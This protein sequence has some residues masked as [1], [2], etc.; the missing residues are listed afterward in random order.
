MV[1]GM[2]SGDD[3][4]KRNMVKAVKD[5]CGL[6]LAEHEGKW[7]MEIG[8]DFGDASNADGIVD[9][10]NGLCFRRDTR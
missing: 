8:T 1:V 6:A 7:G 4:V 10:G 9:L 3:A 2:W 5:S